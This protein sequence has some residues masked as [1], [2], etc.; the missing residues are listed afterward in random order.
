[1]A[2]YFHIAHTYFLPVLFVKDSEHNMHVSI[3]NYKICYKY[4]RM[5]SKTADYKNY[6]VAEI[7]L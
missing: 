7:P 3:G 6:S 1:L 2:F 5:H 4:T